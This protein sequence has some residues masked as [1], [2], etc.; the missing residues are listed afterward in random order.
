[1]QPMVANMSLGG[2]DISTALEDAV[3]RSVN[4]GV[5]YAIAAGNGVI[6]AC[7]LAARAENFSPAR[8]GD[9]DINAAGGSDGD[10][11]RV[12]GVITTTSSDQTDSDVN[13][14]FG[15]PVT[16]ASPGVGIYST[17]L[18]GGSYESSGTAMASP[19]TAGAAL[20]YLQRYP[21]ASPLEVEAA[22]LGVLDPWTT[23]NLPNA[24][25]R[26]EVSE[27]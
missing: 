22:I 14:N 2:T 27:F 26:L 12:N 20:L 1:M 8:V 17:G 10:T 4:A 19:H 11:K 18:D 3:R 21:D 5:V 23:D 24:D 7:F 6:G 16:V 13:C 25:G 15:A 9:D